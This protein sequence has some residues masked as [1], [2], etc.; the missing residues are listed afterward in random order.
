[1]YLQGG[2]PIRTVRAGLCINYTVSGEQVGYFAANEEWFE[3]TARKGRLVRLLAL[4]PTAFVPDR[5]I[6]DAVRTS[7]SSENT[8]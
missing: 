1:M 3:S 5:I 4:K 2:D 6:T 7:S 8:G